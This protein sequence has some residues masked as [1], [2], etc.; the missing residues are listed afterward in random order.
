MTS[1]RSLLFASIAFS[2][3]IYAFSWYVMA[4]S[5]PSM[6]AAFGYHLQTLGYFTSA[7]LIGAGLFQI[8]AGIFSVRRGATSAAVLGLSVLTVM[9]FASVL[10]GDFLLQVA[11]RFISGAGA[12]FYFGPGLVIS[13]SALSKRSGFASGVYAAMFNVGG[14]I[15]SFTFTL[16]SRDFG[17]Q[18]PFVLTG[19]ATLIA[20]VENVYAFRGYRVEGFL[21]Q[22]NVRQTLTSKNV[23]AV[24]LAVLGLS[25]VNYV[26]AQFLVT[27]LE[28]DLL[29]A[30]GAAGSIAALLFVGGLFG[31]PLMGWFSDRLDRRRLFI[32]LPTVSTVVCVFALATGSLPI[33][34]IGIAAM[35]FF[36]SGAYANS[37]AYPTQLGMELRYAALAVAM[38]NTTG[39][40]YGSLVAPSFAAA[41]ELDGFSLAWLS[42][43]VVSLVPMFFIAFAAEP[44]KMRE[45]EGTRPGSAPGP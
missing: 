6:S 14:I 24:T 38:I 9:S 16:I 22:G 11:L 33:M 42:L 25:A 13:S 27:Y 44:R 28:D 19:V 45:E 40:L 36:M 35:G 41:A 29:L 21:G 39:I 31:G 8:P 32:L 1:N 10:S 43:V 20:L 15:A 26:V 3:T 17:W 37:Y 12:A 7:F 30:A 2:R 18:V 34:V 23:W 4:E 5:F